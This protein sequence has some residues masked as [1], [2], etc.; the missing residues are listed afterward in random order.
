MAS[1]TP[2]ATPW[3]AFEARVPAD[4][5]N[6]YQWELYNLADDPTQNNNLASRE[7]DRLRRM[8][9]IWMM[10]ATRFQVL[11]IS[12]SVTANMIIPRPGPA[13]GR[14]HLSTPRP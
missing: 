1:T 7:P 10:E 4:A 5:L 12:N 14:R 11:P 2:I 8:K 6:G 9:E 3:D 13:A